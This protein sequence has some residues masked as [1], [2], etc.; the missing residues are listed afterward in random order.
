MGSQR[1]HSTADCQMVHGRCQECG[2]DGE[3]VNM[4]QVQQQL[5]QA[6]IH[7][8]FPWLLEYGINVLGN[9]DG[10]SVHI[11]ALTLTIWTQKRLLAW[12]L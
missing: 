2:A 12:I 9:A 1:E 8:G 5:E 3:A 11:I 6:K 10:V 7:M 4:I